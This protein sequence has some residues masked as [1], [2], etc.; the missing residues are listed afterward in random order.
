MVNN[1]LRGM[2]KNQARKNIERIIKEK[3]LVFIDADNL[4]YTDTSGIVK[5]YTYAEWAKLIVTKLILQLDGDKQ[6]QGMSSKMGMS[7]A[8]LGSVGLSDETY[9]EVLEEEYKKIGGKN[10]SK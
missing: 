7:V 8:G 4:R 1:I 5:A 3:R 6:I 2:F 9:I 10:V